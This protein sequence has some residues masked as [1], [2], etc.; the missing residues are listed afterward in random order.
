MKLLQENFYM[1]ILTGQIICND[2]ALTGRLRLI[3]NDAQSEPIEISVFNGYF[4]ETEIKPGIYTAQLLSD[5]PVGTIPEFKFKIQGERLEWR[6]LFERKAPKRL[7]AIAQV[8]PQNLPLDANHVERLKQIPPP[9]P[10]PKDPFPTYWAK[11]E[12]VI[13]EEDEFQELLRHEEVT[14]QRPPLDRKTKRLLEM[15]KRINKP[16]SK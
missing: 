1:T 10:I 11:E 13:I 6:S 9:D 3:A 16:I 15:A 4:I 14:E 2:D 5:R 7:P 8:A 12:F